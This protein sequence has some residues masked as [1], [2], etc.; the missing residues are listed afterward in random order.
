ML[1]SLFIASYARTVRITCLE[2][3]AVDAVLYKFHQIMLCVNLRMSLRVEAT[4][5]ESRMIVLMLRFPFPYIDILL[6]AI[7]WGEVPGLDTASPVSSKS[8]WF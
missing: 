5:C 2:Q 1:S 3:H 6:H 8:Y 7:F 4:L